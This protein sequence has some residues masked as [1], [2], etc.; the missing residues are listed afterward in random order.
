[1]TVVQDTKKR[2]MQMGPPILN[3]ARNVG[4]PYKTKI[5]FSPR[6]LDN[7]TWHLWPL[8]D[9]EEH[10]DLRKNSKVR[11]HVCVQCVQFTGYN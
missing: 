9:S 1:M 4:V 6:S 11:Q 8:S 3:N 2:K 5:L 7:M 10:L